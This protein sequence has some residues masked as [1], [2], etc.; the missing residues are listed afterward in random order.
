MNL[1][2]YAPIADRVVIIYESKL[3]DSMFVIETAYG[4]E[5]VNWSRKIKLEE[6]LELVEIIGEL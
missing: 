3:T 5:L 2:G 4:G 6:I 1:V